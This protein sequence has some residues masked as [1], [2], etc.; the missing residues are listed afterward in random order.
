MVS[1]M[2]QHPLIQCKMEQRPSAPVGINI[3]Q[4]M[5]EGGGANA[6]LW[7]LSIDF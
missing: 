4:L 1:V 7:W 6:V 5:C 3:M 2:E